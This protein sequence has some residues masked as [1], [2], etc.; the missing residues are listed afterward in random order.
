MPPH[1]ELVANQATTLVY[2]DCEAS[3]RALYSVSSFSGDV[4][5]SGVLSEGPPGIYTATYSP[6]AGYYNVRVSA[7]CPDGF[8]I[9]EADVQFVPL[10][11]PSPDNP[12]AS[13]AALPYE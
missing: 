13:A 1:A 6:P 10:A 8:F 5:S 7:D 4:V 9:R 11:G 3:S 12:A 2:F